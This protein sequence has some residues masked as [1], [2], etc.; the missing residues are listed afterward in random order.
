M[1]KESDELSDVFEILYKLFGSVKLQS[2]TVFN[3]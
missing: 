1:T 3:R 2:T